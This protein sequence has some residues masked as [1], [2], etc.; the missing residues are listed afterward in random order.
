MR[1]WE[2]NSCIAKINELTNQSWE[3]RRKLTDVQL[4]QE[5][6]THALTDRTFSFLSLDVAELHCPDLHFMRLPLVQVP[7]TV[8]K[9]LEN[10]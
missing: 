2:P 7:M 8:C 1:R 3:K 4:G 6:L 9:V 10:E 5:V